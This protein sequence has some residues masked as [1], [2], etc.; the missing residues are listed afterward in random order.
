LPARQR[1]ATIENVSGRYQ[2]LDLEEPARRRQIILRF[3]LSSLM[4][5][6]NLCSVESM[7]YA[8]LTYA[9]LSA[10]FANLR[11][12]IVAD[13]R[14][15]H[16]PLLVLLM[17]GRYQCG[18]FSPLRF[19]DAQNKLARLLEEFGPPT[20]PANVADP[21]WRLQNDGVW[22][23]ESEL[24]ERIA[25]TVTPPNTGTLV[26]SDAR[27]NF[28]PEVAA[29]FAVRPAYVAWLGRDLLAAH[30]PP[31]LYED[32]C[33]A[34]GLDLY[35][36]ESGGEQAEVR[37][38]PHRTR[39]SEFRSRIIR[40]YEHRCAVTGW[41]LRIY[42]VDAGLEAAHIKWHT[43]G[44]PCVETNGIALNALHHKLFDIGAFTLSSDGAL[45]RI[46]VSR[47][48]HGG[49]FARETLIGLHGKPM[50]PP[51]DPG[52]LPSREFVGWHNREVFKGEPRVL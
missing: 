45:P 22:K 9:E 16:K 8:D 15:P 47:D 43:A 46:L 30:F 24:G 38:Q 7:S 21:F 33:S 49:D 27:G 31:S 11:Q 26:Q 18:D 42:N 39:D 51:Q 4:H 12:A 19:S 40:A 17:L 50:R 13:R 32:I 10:R 6:A 2:R 3:T 28:S 5:E 36:I 29:T 25:E 35:D 44:G 41:D 20:R 48:V 52:W 1:G 37:I 23:V 14:A 34:V